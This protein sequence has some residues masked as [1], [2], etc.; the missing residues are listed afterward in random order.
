MRKISYELQDSANVTVKIVDILGNTVKLLSNVH[1]KG[2]IY[3]VNFDPDNLPI[4]KYYYKI[5][6]NGALSENE[7][8]A[9]DGRLLSS[10]QFKV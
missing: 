3:E 6:I 1:D 10:G 4:G 5:F 9:Q 7:N 2:G 8:P